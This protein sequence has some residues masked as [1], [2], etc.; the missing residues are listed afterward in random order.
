MATLNFREIAKAWL[1]V[2]LWM[3][4]MFFGSTDLMSSEHTAQF[5]TPF[6]HWLKPNISAATLVQAQVLIRKAAHVTE[7]AILAGLIFR[8]LRG[9]IGTF[10]LRAVLAFAAAMTFAVTDEFHQAFVPSRTSSL[11]DIFI[12][13]AGAIAGIAICRAI[14]QALPHRH[15][16]G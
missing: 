9:L 2:L 13:C 12:D 14:H 6:L 1:P 11:G 10:W 8:A 7:Y 5:L 16:A 4:L 15:S 3:G